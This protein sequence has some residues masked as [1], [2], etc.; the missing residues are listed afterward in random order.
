MMTI[1]VNRQFPRTRCRRMR[2]A[3][4]SRRLMAETKLTVDDL[5]YP[6]FILEGQNRLE[7][8]LSMPGIARMSVDLLLKEAE[9]LVLLGIPAIA[10]FPVIDSSKKSLLA[11]ASYDSEGLI[12]RAVR[13]LKQ[14]YPDLGIITDVALDPYTSHGQDGIIDDKNY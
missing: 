3:S 7:P 9:E 13:Q 6:M 2:Q 5:I 10:L 14:A 12:Q 11:E 8:V 1:K 4:F